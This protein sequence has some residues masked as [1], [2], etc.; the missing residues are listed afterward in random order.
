M[1]SICILAIC[2]FHAKVAIWSSICI[3]AICLIDKVGCRCRRSV[4]QLSDD[5][6]LACPC[7]RSVLQL[8][9]DPPVACN[10]ALDSIEP[11]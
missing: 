5:P 8:S 4:L 3:L 9:D 10:L 11:V 1:S 6:I 2:L 7:H